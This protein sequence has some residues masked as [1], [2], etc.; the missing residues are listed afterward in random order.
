MVEINPLSI[1]RPR[2]TNMTTEYFFSCH[3]IGD[4]M[5]LVVNLEAIETI[6]LPILWQLMCSQAP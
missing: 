3:M 2:F 5:F 4:G 6:V 1:K